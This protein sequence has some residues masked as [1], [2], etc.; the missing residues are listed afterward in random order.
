MLRKKYFSSLFLLGTHANITLYEGQR[1]GL[2]KTFISSCSGPRAGNAIDD[3][4]LKFM[5][6]VVGAQVFK[7]LKSTELEVYT[8]FI[9]EFEIKK[10]SIKSYTTSDILIP[11]P[12][13]LMNIVKKH[14]GGMDAT[15]KKSI[16]RKCILISG[17]KLFVN[18]QTFRD[19]FEPTII[20]LL[21]HLE[22]LLRHPK[23]LDI[24]HIIMIGGFSECEL[25]QTA[26][27]DKFPKKIFLIPEEPDL[28][29]LR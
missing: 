15:M 5:E 25:V 3:A 24:Q 22:Q 28:A 1:D 12:I 11:L 23:I 17:Q 4:F 7:E 21:K 18:P 20:S 16:Y 29:V 26:F 6:D 8:Y 27:K 14:C 13:G 10:R 2:P 9:N 19:L